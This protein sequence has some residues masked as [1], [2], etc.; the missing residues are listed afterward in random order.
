[1]RIAGAGRRR[2]MRS[3]PIY[4]VSVRCVRSA[5]EASR[6]ASAGRGSALASHGTSHVY[7]VTDRKDSS[8]RARVRRRTEI[9]FFVFSKW[10]CTLYR[11]RTHTTHTTHECRA[12]QASDRARR[13]TGGATADRDS[14]RPDESKVAQTRPKTKRARALVGRRPSRPWP[15][16]PPRP[17]PWLPMA[18]ADLS[19]ASRVA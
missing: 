5:V 11:S 2:S 6:A 9:H 19:H 18:M 14:A 13:G 16:V 3:W 7:T 15:T 4:W 17:L 10:K 12:S 1:M 8:A